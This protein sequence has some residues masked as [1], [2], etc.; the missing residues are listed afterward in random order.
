MWN[1]LIFA[2]LLGV[3]SCVVDVCD[4]GTTL[5]AGSGTTFS[6]VLDTGSR[7]AVSVTE[8]K[9]RERKAGAG[10]TAGRAKLAAAGAQLG[11]RG[12]LRVFVP[13]RLAARRAKARVDA[14]ATVW[15]VEWV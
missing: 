7:A 15:I 6:A 9:P 11:G 5:R 8:A 3:G 2:S 13:V 12:L 4:S 14:I 10:R 1:V